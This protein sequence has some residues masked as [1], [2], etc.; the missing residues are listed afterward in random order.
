M[1]SF[2]ALFSFRNKFWHVSS[3]WL[4]SI[5]HDLYIKSWLPVEL[6]KL[7]AKLIRNMAG[8]MVKLAHIFC[9]LAF[10]SDDTGLCIGSD[11]VF[12]VSDIFTVWIFCQVSENILLLLLQRYLFLDC[13]STEWISFLQKTTFLCEE[14]VVRKVINYYMRTAGF[15]PLIH[16]SS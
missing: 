12:S 11:C 3:V 1:A 6:D 10:S 2:S 7:Q 15:L 8:S 5:L 4:K 14:I 9:I 13:L 16:M